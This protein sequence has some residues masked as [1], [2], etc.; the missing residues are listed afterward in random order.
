MAKEI[1][2]STVSGYLMLSVGILVVGAAIYPREAE[3]VP[4][5]F[6]PPG[7]PR[8]VRAPEPRPPDRRQDS[9]GPD[10]APVRSVRFDR[11]AA[12]DTCPSSPARYSSTVHRLQVEGPVRTPLHPH[13]ASRRHQPRLDALEQ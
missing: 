11:G 6:S 2:R 12:I 5:I 10:N 9:V 7:V 4:P 1:I 13:D 3:V 8:E